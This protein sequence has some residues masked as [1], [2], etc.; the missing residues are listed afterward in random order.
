M[1]IRPIRASGRWFTL[2]AAS[3]PLMLSGLYATVPGNASSTAPAGVRAAAA[4]TGHVAA[5][6]VVHAATSS[7]PFVPTAAE[8]AARA[9]DMKLLD[10]LKKPP[11][12]PH[13]TAADVAPL[14]GPQASPARS[15]APTTFT[16]FKD[17]PLP[18][19]C[20]GSCAQSTVNEPDTANSGKYILQTSNW[21]IAYTTNGGA[22][23]PTW[24]YQ[25]PYS[26][27]SGF[28]CD[29]TVTYVPS[30]D[31]FVYEG[32]TL[33]S[34]STQGITIATTRSTAPTSWCVY[35][36]D[37]S[38]F[39]GTSGDLLDYPKIAYSNNN[40]YLTWNHYNSSGGWVDTGLARLPIDPLAACSGFGYNYLT[41]N[42]NFTFGLTYG[43][44]SLDTFYW[45][46]NW[47]TTSSGS[48]TEERIYYWPENGSSYFYV[49]RSVTS[50]NFSGG[51]CASQDG[52]VT[53]WCSRLDPRWE[54]AWTSRA[55][56]N[57]QANSAFSGDTILG[58]AI[59]AGPGG[60][61]PFPY[62]IYEYFKL[63]ALSFIQTSAT[64]NDGF[65][66]A[67]AGCAPDAHGYVGC[68]MSWGGGTGTGS[69][70][71]DYYPG[72]LILLQ[73]NVNPTQPWGYDFNLFGSGNASAWGDYM[74]TQ[75][76]EPDVGPFITTEWAVNGSGIV[77][78]HVV[79]W[80]RGNEYGYSRFK[81]S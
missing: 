32:L 39:G 58:V 57:A 77:V 55:E 64:F 56:Y 27:S 52:K 66:F 74:V 47:Y 23:P 62:V 76:F 7:K 65:A 24:N 80:G 8:K 5:G 41:R 33:G 11:L 6:T 38:A 60:G 40:L 37:A 22:S 72:G 18:A 63:N 16:V 61:D 15:N 70:A 71:I 48:G 17:A 3:V 29:Q 10:S 68:T 26:L 20:S 73:D 21:D 13:A 81:T 49:D 9:R 25:N 75:P 54:T 46:S 51:S 12:G 2:I 30:R 28:C 31:R 34:G 44:S 19:S 67:Y 14:R 4:R 79:I 36:F 42:D 78:P 59:T 35:H 69:S 45:V 1:A 43:T 50:Y 53:N